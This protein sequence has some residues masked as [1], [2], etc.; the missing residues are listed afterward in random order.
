MGEQERWQEEE[1]QEAKVGERLQLED[2]AAE[3]TEKPLHDN[4]GIQRPLSAK[5]A[6]PDIADEPEQ[7]QC[8]EDWSSRCNGEHRCEDEE[9]LMDR[10][11]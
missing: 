4:E 9:S 5:S 1:P 8:S 6:T 2:R 3:H 7:E 10:E 11:E